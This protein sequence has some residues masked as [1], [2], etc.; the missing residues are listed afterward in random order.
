MSQDFIAWYRGQKGAIQIFLDYELLD[1]AMTGLEVLEALDLGT[2]ALLETSHYENPDNDDE[3]D[4][5]V[6]V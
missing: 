4:D 1:N 6:L 5:S 2:N 3:G